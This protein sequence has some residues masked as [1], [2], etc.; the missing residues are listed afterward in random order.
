M[1]ECP[2]CKTKDYMSW[3]SDVAFQDI[4]IDGNGVISFYECL[5]CGTTV[6]IR[7]PEEAEGFS[8]LKEKNR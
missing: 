4:G 8:R 1:I 5:K 2:K 6:E 7:I 3:D